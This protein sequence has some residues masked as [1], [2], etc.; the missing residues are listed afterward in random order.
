MKKKF[1][2][3]ASAF[4]RIKEIRDSEEI[5][6]IQELKNPPEF[7]N[8]E[9][10]V[11]TLMDDGSWQFKLDGYDTIYDYPVQPI[12]CEGD[13]LTITSSSSSIMVTV[14]KVNL[15][16]SFPP[17]LTSSSPYVIFMGSKIPD[18][19]SWYWIIYGKLEKEKKKEMTAERAKQVAFC[20]LQML[21]RELNRRAD[22]SKA[23]WKNVD[24]YIFSELDIEIGELEEIYAPY[25]SA[26]VYGGSCFEDDHSPKDYDHRFYDS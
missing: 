2:V 21:R 6:I 12:C 7:R 13:H 15:A 11:P 3:S 10:G 25:K 17:V 1:R 9:T 19:T 8:G 5:A 14:E 20:A 4:R 26:S 24:D 18:G 16:R 22:G 23:D